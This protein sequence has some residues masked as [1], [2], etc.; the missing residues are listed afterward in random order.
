[1]LRSPRATGSERIDPRGASVPAVQETQ[2]V[3]DFSQAWEREY[4]DADDTS[5]M[6]LVARL[7]RL[8]VLIEAFEADA[9]APF[10]LMPSDYAVLAALRRAGEP[11]ELAPTELYTA[12]ERSSGGMTKML[13]RLESLG[14]VTRV[15]DSRDRRSTL[16]R[17]TE[18]GKKTEQQAFETFVEKT[19]ELLSSSSRRDLARISESVHELLGIIEAGFRR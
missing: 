10:D 17:L 8:S 19:H 16:V 13:K 9:L 5:G 11:Y 12:L 2:W 4:P 7:A 3:D 18:A 1:M 6:L 15:P 14:L